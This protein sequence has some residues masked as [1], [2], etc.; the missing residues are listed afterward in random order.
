MELQ[1]YLGLKR[2]KNHWSE[3][4]AL[5]NDIYWSAGTDESAL[6][7]VNLVGDSYLQHTEVGRLRLMSTLLMCK[8]LQH[9]SGGGGWETASGNARTTKGSSRSGM[10]VA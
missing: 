6:I 5:L 3:T 7:K 4:F 2:D 9:G 10:E 8:S 1:N